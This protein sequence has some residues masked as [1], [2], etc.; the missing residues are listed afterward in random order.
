VL[1]LSR[2]KSESI[3]VSDSIVITVVEVRSD[4]VRLGVEAPKEVPVH[5]KE[6]WEAIQ[7]DG[8]RK[9]KGAKPCKS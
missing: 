4:K 8:V 2:K 9:M 6:V 7:R 1:V 3:V 5:R